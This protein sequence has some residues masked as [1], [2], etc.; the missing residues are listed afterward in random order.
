MSRLTIPVDERDHLRGS[1]RA[2]ITLVEF[3][4]FQCPFCGRTYGVLKELEARYARDLRVAFRHFP[5]TQIHPL[6]MIAAETAEAAGAQGKFWE[7]HDVLFE[8]QPRFE[9]ERLVAYVM[10]LDLDVDEFHEAI[11]SHRHVPKIR[12]DFMGGVRSGVNGTPTLFLNGMRYDGQPERT[13]L[14]HAIENLLSG[15]THVAP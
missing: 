2:P 7:M 15:A 5:L 10:N 1:L 14:V 8:N 4:D 11:A 9:Y 6:A 12:D 13:P 3:G